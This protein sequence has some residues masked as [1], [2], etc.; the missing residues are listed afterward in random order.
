MCAIRSK[1]CVTALL[2][3]SEDSPS[4]AMLTRVP[5]SGLARLTG[6]QH[7]RMRDDQTAHA[8]G[9][10]LRR[11]RR[12]RY[13][14]DVL[15]QLERRFTI[16]AGELRTPFGVG[17]LAA[18]GFTVFQYFNVLDGAAVVQRD[19]EGYVIMLAYDLI[20]DEPTS[21]RRLPSTELFV[22]DVGVAGFLDHR[23]LRIG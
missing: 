11:Q 5:N 8:V 20:R 18:I 12:P 6:G 16:L 3:T 21:G 23:D 1:H 7:E 14:L 22:A 13:V 10:V 2:A 15:G 17:D 19:H 9:D 4:T